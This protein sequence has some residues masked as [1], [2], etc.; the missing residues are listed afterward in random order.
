VPV[1]DTESAYCSVAVEIDFLWLTQKE[2][3]VH[4]RISEQLADQAPLS[5]VTRL[6][7]ISGACQIAPVCNSLGAQG[8]KPLDNFF[9]IQFFYAFLM[10]IDSLLLLFL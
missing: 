5:L 10:S 2:R 6:L 8:L 4:S 3:N 9:Q 7:L 1:F